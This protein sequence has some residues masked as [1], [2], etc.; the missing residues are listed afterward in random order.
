LRLGGKAATAEL[1][2]SPD[3]HPEIQNPAPA[4]AE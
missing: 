1:E 3:A 2:C 4:M